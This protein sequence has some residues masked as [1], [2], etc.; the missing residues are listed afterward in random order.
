MATFVKRGGEVEGPFDDDEVRRRLTAGELALTDLGRRSWMPGW[1]TLR[2]LYPATAAAVTSTTSPAAPRAAA[3]PAR[4]I[5]GGLVEVAG[6]A[7]DFLRPVQGRLGATARPNGTFW[8]Y[9]VASTALFR[10]RQD[11]RQGGRLTEAGERF[12]AG[13]AAYLAILAL[14]AWG[15]RGLRASTSV[16]F[17]P[18]AD[19]SELTVTTERERDGASEDYGHDFLRDTRGLLLRP[20][21]HFPWLRDQVYVMQSTQ[22]PTPEYL[23]LYGAYLLQSEQGSGNWPRTSRVGGLPED[24]DESKRLLV[25]DLHDDCGLP[26]DDEALRK[27]S[28]W[29]V[30]PPYGWQLNDGQDYNMMTFFSQVSQQHVVPL[31]VAI[32]Y[33]RRLLTSQALEIRN[34]AARCLMVYRVPP[35]DR[36]ESVHYRQAM[37]WDD[38]PEASAAMAKYQHQLE[39]VEATPAWAEQVDAE[40]RRWLVDMPPLLSHR[41]AAEG[42]PDYAALGR[43]PPERI[44]EGLAGLDA[45]LRRYPD[46]WVLAVIHASLRMRGAD[47]AGGEAALRALVETP[48]DTFEGHSRLGTLLKQQGRREEAL[49]VY[50]DALRRWPWCHQAVYACMW[51]VTDGMVEPA[52]RA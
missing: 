32:D 4:P 3:A 37:E 16:R 41:T 11:L 13:A 49:A 40:R 29:L 30:F 36:L 39:G 35:R 33:L 5:E 23:Y 42:D 51:L 26:R 19:D 8:S 24:L 6:L 17:A 9:R 38:W 22:L 7:A 21:A 48:P 12:A 2:E 14:T 46:D 44:A 34:L 52:P 27:L 31:D 47:P 25:D 28:W 15:R 45:L 10:L 50:E 1:K 43:L 20:P 18:G